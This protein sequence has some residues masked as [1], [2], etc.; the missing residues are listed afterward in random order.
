MD[1][2]KKTFLENLRLKTKLP[3]LRKPGK[4]QLAK[5]GRLLA[6][7]RSIS[8]PDLRLVPGEAFFT[9][10]LVSPDYDVISFGI[11]PHLS[12]TDSNASG[13]VVDGP[14]FTDK[15]N[16][17]VPENKLRVPT[18]HTAADFN[19]ISAP[20]ETLTL[21][22]GTEVNLAKE[23]LYAR[24]DKRAK[25]NAAQFTFDTTPAPR[26]VLAIEQVLSP[27]PDLAERETLSDEDALTERALSGSLVAALA[28]ANPP[29]SEKGTPPAIRVTAHPDSV[30]LTLDTLGT[31]FESA[32]GT[33]LDSACGTISEERVN[34]PW[35]TESE[36]LDREPCSPFL[37]RELATE[38]ALLEEEQH[39]ETLEEIAEVSFIMSP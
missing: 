9:E 30:P 36:E 4:K 7:R 3:N 32:D 35:T 24:V 31:P 10:S 13:S 34:V 25:G 2:K 17:S 37:M 27:I 16:E 33:S 11:S 38:Q 8:V 12:D 26:S 20:V 23:P 15:L 28:R 39:E 19:R 29:S 1:V 6:H 14:P 18:D 21:Y 22:E 5:Q